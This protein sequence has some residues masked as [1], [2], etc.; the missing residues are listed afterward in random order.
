MRFPV[1]AKPCRRLMRVPNMEM[2]RHLKN[3][4]TRKRIPPNKAWPRVRKVGPFVTFFACRLNP[5]SGASSSLLLPM[6]ME[7][8]PTRSDY[9][10]VWTALSSTSDQAKI[11]VIGSTD[12]D[13]FSATGA[14][15]LTFLQETVGVGH[16]D[17]VLEIGCGVG[18][19]GRFVAPLCQ[20]WIGCD[21]SPN[22]VKLA[23]DRLRDLANIELHEISGF[24][25]DGIADD[26][27]D[28]VYCTVVFM[29]LESWDR[30]NYVLEAMRVLRRG[31]RIYIDNVNLCSE[32]GWHVFENHRTAYAPELRP[33][34]ITQCSTP[35]EIETYLVRAGFGQVLLKTN[36]PFVRAWAVKA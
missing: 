8:Q 26:S 9:K 11:H 36:E 22:M 3:G 28:V 16:E 32:A 7:R 5:Q 6:L 20:R 13:A 17:I 21:V 18:R 27:V 15:T 31:G 10:Q 33:P 23:A 4:D 29:H 2:T 14:Q 30:Y 25:L 1:R 34:H 35:Q 19:V 12:E 24:N